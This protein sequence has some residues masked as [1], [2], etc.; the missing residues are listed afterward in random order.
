MPWVWSPS[1]ALK[2]W[3]RQLANCCFSPT[4]EWL[5]VLGSYIFASNPFITST[6]PGFVLYNITD[7]IMATD[8]CSWFTRWLLSYPITYSA[9][10]V[11]L[12]IDRTRVS[13]GTR[14][15][16]MLIGCVVMLP[17]L[18]FS[19]MIRDWWGFSNIAAMILSVVVRQ[20]M[21][22]QLR[23]A[24]DRDVDSF[25]LD[26]GQEVKVFLTLPNGKA[27][28]IYGPRQAI[29]HCLLTDPRPI[30]PRVYMALRVLAW[31]AF[32]VHVITLGMATLISQMLTVT[33]LIVGSVL[34]GFG[35]GYR[36]ETLG[37]R[38]RLE[39]DRGDPAWVRSQAY[40]KLN[41]TEV[42]E[43]YMVHWSLFPQ[44]KNEVWWTKYRQ[45]EA[46]LRSTSFQSA[47][48]TEKVVAWT[49]VP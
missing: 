10:T 14:L 8:I 6:Q 33:V 22:S 44:R 1:L 2:P 11:R 45:K 27:V 35:V 28:T 42:E 34:T 30:R 31:T 36:P 20:Q 19:A 4:T 9:T 46:S 48:S 16:S 26:P 3:P 5:P 38:L 24:V 21:V 39:V 25:S 7:G 32:G 23:D 49:N 29:V 40:A 47:S 12:R 17:I 41:L 18:V 37:S 15:L 13:A 43:D